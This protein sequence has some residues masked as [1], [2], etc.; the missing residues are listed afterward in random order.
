MSWGG[1]F[2]Q[3]RPFILAKICIREDTMAN[4]SKSSG[5]GKKMPKPP[6]HK[7]PGGHMMPDKAMKKMMGKGKK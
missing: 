7:M 5:A 2:K 4:K 6:M 3:R 1:L